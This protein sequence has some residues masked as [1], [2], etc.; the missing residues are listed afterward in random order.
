MEK[1]DELERHKKFNT[2]LQSVV[3]DKDGGGDNKEFED[4][5]AL[6]NR[7]RNLKNENKKLM[8]RVRVILVVG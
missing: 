3:E 7:F 5:D 4:I 2:F 8:L 6:I 1:K